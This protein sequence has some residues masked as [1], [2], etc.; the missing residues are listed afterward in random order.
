MDVGVA[1]DI[2]VGVGVGVG[3]FCVGVVVCCG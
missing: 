1:I 3:G 2:G